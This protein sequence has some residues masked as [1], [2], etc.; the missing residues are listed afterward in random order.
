L[1]DGPRESIEPACP[2][3]KRSLERPVPVQIGPGLQIPGGRCSACGARYLFD[4]TGKNVGEIMM[5]A[6]ELIASDLSREASELIAGEDF[7]DA[8]LSYDWRTHRSSGEAKGFADRY[9]RLY[10]IKA[11]LKTASRTGPD[12]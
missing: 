11:K 4:P 3:C 7:D 9:G 1:R 8:I 2:F 6:L 12:A 10:M 5:Q